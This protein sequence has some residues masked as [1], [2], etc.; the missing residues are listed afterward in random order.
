MPIRNALSFG[1]LFAGWLLSSCATDRH[2]GKLT[3]TAIKQS[4]SSQDLPAN[5]GALITAT[6]NAFLAGDS[7][8][9]P[10]QRAAIL[11]QEITYVSAIA[12]NVADIG[13]FITQETG[14]QVDTS[15]LQPAQPSGSLL[16]AAGT[17][18]DPVVVVHHTGPLYQLLDQLANKTGS[19]WNFSEGQ[20]RFFRTVTETFTL[21]VLPQ[22]NSLKSTIDT[23]NS[24]QSAG[25][26]SGGG[27]G[28]GG[29]G[30]SG[31][32]GGGGGGTASSG[33][34]VSSTINRDPWKDILQSAQ[35]VAGS[36]HVTVDP[37]AGTVTVTGAP[38]EVRQVAELVK[39]YNH[40]AAQQV[41][42]SLQVYKVELDHE[43]NYGL[44]PNVVFKDTLGTHGW[45]LSGLSLPPVP[46]GTTPG[47]ITASIVSSKT[48]TS[49]YS[50]STLA[51][52]AL[53]TLGKVV[54]T[55][56]SSEVTQNGHP[57]VLTSGNSIGYLYSVSTLLS[58]NVGQQATLTP[59]TINTG[60][61]WTV[62]PRVIDGAVHLGVAVT[63]GTL[64]SL[65]SVSSGGNSIQTPNVNILA[66]QNEVILHPS[67]A[68]LLTGL[69]DTNA[70]STHR[71]VGVASNPLL[72]GGMDAATKR[73][74]IAIVIT[75]KVL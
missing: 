45:S 33:L 62:T 20:V 53:S 52:Q 7:L 41:Q 11:N 34:N 61:S 10:P 59:G 47:N 25:G 24:G 64:V 72:G 38:A 31:G 44:S 48:E 73:S 32:Q 21:A 12:V 58:A 43:D 60:V 28:G 36:A 57:A 23:T 39:A 69:D 19:S 51:V 42:V 13:S 54:E 5:R 37:T 2:V 63:N 75:A 70:S 3:N 16:G 74:I 30:G 4:E 18:R 26:A 66:L 1:C 27:G 50:G 68:L 46:S 71:G 65:T 55:F 40:I 22:S 29:G 6:S 8:D 9:A 17:S 15:A 67:E 35:A 14:L 56:S 49:G